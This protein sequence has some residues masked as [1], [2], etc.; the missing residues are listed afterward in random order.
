MNGSNSDFDSAA[1][2][3]VSPMYEHAEFGQDSEKVF[4]NILIINLDCTPTTHCRS[5]WNELISP[6]LLASE[7]ISSMNDVQV[8]CMSQ[9][10]ILSVIRNGST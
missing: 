1:A 8:F 2:A 6:D 3:A 9:F 7:P 5:R 10:I 4:V